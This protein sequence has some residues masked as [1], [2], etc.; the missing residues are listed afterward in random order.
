MRTRKVARVGAVAT[1]M[2]LMGAMLALVPASQ[3]FAGGG[4]HLGATES[5][6]DTV[7]LDQACFTPT[8]LYVEPG[9]TVTWT[10][11]DIMAHVVVGQAYEW[12]T[13]EDLLQGDIFSHTFEAEG[14][15]PYT[16]YLHP[17][18]NGTVIVGD[19]DAGSSGGAS[20]AGGSAGSGSGGADEGAGTAAAEAAAADDNAPWRA[21]TLVLAALFL[22]TLMALAVTLRA[23]R[24]PVVAAEA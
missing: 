21:A 8:N 18:M 13:R 23:R 16:C 17:G 4:C 10:N 3:V 9:T 19:A 7:V 1:T 20:G 6:G 11:K 5:T 22:G 14:T 12:G 2:A 15:Y 24:Q